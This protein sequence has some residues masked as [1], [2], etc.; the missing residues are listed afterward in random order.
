MFKI[1]SVLNN[2]DT[3]N[4]CNFFIDDME[5]TCDLDILFDVT[6]VNENIYEDTY[7]NQVMSFKYDKDSKLFKLYVDNLDDGSKC[8]TGKSINEESFR[9]L[10]DY[11]KNLCDAYRIQNK[12]RMFKVVGDG[13]KY[14]CFSELILEK[15]PIK[16]LQRL[17]L[18]MKGKY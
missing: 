1:G 8:F 15:Q 3:G 6:D 16:L 2:N 9:E 10:L 14:G 13:E 11:F 7:V 17:T 18:D 12:K 4:Y 5:I